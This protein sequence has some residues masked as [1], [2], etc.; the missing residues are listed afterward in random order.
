MDSNDKDMTLDRRVKI[1]DILE[2]DGQLKVSELSKKFN[3]SDVTI[4]NDLAQ[5]EGKGLLIR[6]RGGGIKSQRV[7]IDFHLNEKAKRHLTEKQKI[8]KRTA[9]L[10]NDDETIIL[11]SGTTTLEIT[12]HLSHFKNLTII[13]NALNLAGQLINYPQ[14]NVIMLGGILRRSSLS[15]I[16]PIS[17]ANIRNYYCDKFIMGVDSIDS[18]YGISTPT[19]EEAQLNKLMID[20]SKEVIV[21][22]DSSKFLRKSFAFIAPVK[23]INTIVTDSNI[24]QEEYKNLINSGIKIIIVD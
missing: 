8:G 15:M 21:V 6:T 11:D 22:T 24:P 18:Q 7:N 17:E 2:A 12:K 14:I 10:I 16:G 23:I 1:I 19:I 4:R 13:T 5:L 3:V 20:I 9:E